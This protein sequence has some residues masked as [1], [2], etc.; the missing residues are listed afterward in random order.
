VYVLGDLYV[1]GDLKAFLA[2]AGLVQ[3]SQDA[4]GG[5]AMYF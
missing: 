5:Q 1:P 3:L 2:H 4:Y